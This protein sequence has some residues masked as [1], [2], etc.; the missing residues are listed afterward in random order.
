MGR[1]PLLTILARGF[2]GSAG[3]SIP[4]LGLALFCVAVGDIRWVIAAA[5]ASVSLRYRAH[6]P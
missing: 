6:V 1:T 5:A 4:D 2:T 3:Y